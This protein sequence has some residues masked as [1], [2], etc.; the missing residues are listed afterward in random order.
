MWQLFTLVLFLCVCNCTCVLKGPI[1]IAELYTDC[2]T[3]VY[4]CN[5]FCTGHTSN[6]TLLLVLGKT[7]KPVLRNGN[8]E[9]DITAALKTRKPLRKTTKVNL[10]EGAGPGGRGSDLQ[11]RLQSQLKGMKLSTEIGQSTTYTSC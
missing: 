5:Y 11:Q 3:S 8:Q 10:I 7:R 4:S 6:A 2:G 9:F 1:S